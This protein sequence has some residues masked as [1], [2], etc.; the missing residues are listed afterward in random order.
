MTPT[1]PSRPVR[2]DVWKAT[3]NMVLLKTA[4]GWCERQLV[5]LHRSE[6]P[7]Q[8][9]DHRNHR[10]TAVG[11][12]DRRLEP[13]LAKSRFVRAVTSTAV[14]NGTPANLRRRETPKSLWAATNKGTSNDESDALSELP[15]LAVVSRR[16]AQ[17][18]IAKVPRSISTAQR[19]AQPNYGGVVDLCSQL[20]IWP[21]GEVGKLRSRS[22]S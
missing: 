6:T 15:F 5:S 11:E 21:P 10:L 1:L 19:A 3:Y 13:Q 2:G 16:R 14:G 22:L 20:T 9:G 8:I 18:P 17:E 7:T 4:A 12:N